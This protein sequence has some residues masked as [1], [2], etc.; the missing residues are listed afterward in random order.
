MRCLWKDKTKMRMPRYVDLAENSWPLFVM[1]KATTYGLTHPRFLSIDWTRPFGIH[2]IRKKH[3]A[4]DVTGRNC[5]L[6][7]W[8]V[9]KPK[10]FV[11]NLGL[12]VPHR[13]S[14]G[15]CGQTLCAGA[16]RTAWRTTIWCR[17]LLRARSCQSWWAKSGWGWSSRCWAG[18][19]G[20]L[21]PRAWQRA[22]IIIIS[23][24]SV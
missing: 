17:A 23:Y 6:M 15:I 12:G 18:G 4:R 3:M 7:P 11:L 8:T 20:L 13:S 5:K 16:R 24:E 1:T 10:Q 19:I 21:L 22:I 14:M 9:R 2:R